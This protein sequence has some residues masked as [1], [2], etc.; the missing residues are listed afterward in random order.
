MD[1]LS[2]VSSMTTVVYF[3]TDNAS[4]QG[5]TGMHYEVTETLAHSA[6]FPHE[7]FLINLITNHILIFVGLLGMAKSY[8]VVM[9]VT[10]AISLV[11]MT[12]LLLRARRAIKSDDWYVAC[13]WQLCAHRCMMF[14]GM[15]LLLALV[16]GGIL[17]SVGGDASQLKPGHYALGGVASLPTLL[18]VLVLIVM[19]SDA[20]HKARTGIVP[21]WLVKK[22]PTDREQAAIA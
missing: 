11:V 21:E 9:L 16:V 6:K 22:Y 18:F 12:Y 17:L 2:T 10:P 1:S 8:P 5:D 3:R 14:L 13:H 19:E 15:L 7:I 4:Q 20:L